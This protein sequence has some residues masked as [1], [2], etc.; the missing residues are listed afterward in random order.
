MSL[1][2]EKEESENR[3][4]RQETGISVKSSVEEVSR[5]DKRTPRD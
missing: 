4:G 5:N 1:I 2:L 3:K